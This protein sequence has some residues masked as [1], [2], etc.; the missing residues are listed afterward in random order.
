MVTINIVALEKN[1]L[2]HHNQTF[3]KLLLVCHECVLSNKPALLH[4]M[5]AACAAFSSLF[6]VWGWGLPHSLNKHTKHIM[7]IRGFGHWLLLGRDLKEA[8]LFL[9]SKK[10]V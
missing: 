7:I 4:L 1:C 10:L 5:F 6:K 9:Q 8:L 2:F 3:V